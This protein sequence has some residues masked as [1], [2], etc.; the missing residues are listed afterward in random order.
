[1]N[2][3]QAVYHY[4]LIKVIAIAEACGELDPPK[5]IGNTGCI[6]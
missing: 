2:F 6:R 3:K 1:M 5:Q 4:N